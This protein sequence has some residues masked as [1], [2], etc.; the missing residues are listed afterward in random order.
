MY[1]ILS[2]RKFNEIVLLFRFK[3]YIIRTVKFLNF[4]S[5]SSLDASWSYPLG[6]TSQDY[7][8]KSAR[9]QA[10]FTWQVLSGGVFVQQWNSV[11][12][13][14]D[15][16]KYFL[17]SSNQRPTLYQICWKLDPLSASPP[18]AVQHPQP[19]SPHR[20]QSSNRRI[21]VWNAI[22]TPLLPSDVAG[23]ASDHL[24]C[25]RRAEHSV[26]WIIWLW[27]FVRSIKMSCTFCP[28]VSSTSTSFKTW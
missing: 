9:R 28:K 26:L 17:W 21:L 7:F 23:G 11:A 14:N 8:R 13:I 19:V 5:T 18:L 6:S 2:T 25:N 27:F 10:S 1:V 24:E 4:F 12:H 20:S 22:T 3:H 16:D 15:S